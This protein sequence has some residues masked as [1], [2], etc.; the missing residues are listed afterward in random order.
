MNFCI[1]TCLVGSLLLFLFFQTRAQ[2][3]EAPEFS[4]AQWYFD[5]FEK[6]SNEPIEM[7]LARNDDKRLAAVET[8]DDSAKTSVSIE[9]GLLYLTRDLTDKR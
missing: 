2:E 1:R 6:R 4:Y 8:Q 9:A 3:T 7:L 5:F